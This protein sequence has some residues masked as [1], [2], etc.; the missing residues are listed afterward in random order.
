MKIKKYLI[1]VLSLV[2]LIIFTP[3]NVFAD[4]YPFWK[5]PYDNANHTH[6]TEYA[7]HYGSYTTGLTLNTTYT[8]NIYFDGI[9][10]T[11]GQFDYLEIPFLIY[12][13][14]WDNPVD[15]TMA[16]VPNADTMYYKFTNLFIAPTI[17]YTNG[18]YEN[19]GICTIE[20]YNYNGNSVNGIFKCNVNRVSDGITKI[21]IKHYLN[22]SLSSTASYG[23]FF[24]S[25]GWFNLIYGNNDN[26]SIANSINSQTNSITNAQ[27]GTTNAINDMNSN[28]TN[29]DGN[30][31]ADNAN[32]IQSF[33]NEIASNS[34]ITSL[35]VMPITFFQA[36]LNSVNGTCSPFNIGDLFGKNITF[37][38]VNMQA[39]LGNTL[40]GVIDTIISAFFIWGMSKRFIS[41]FSNMTSLKDGKDEVG[42]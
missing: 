13:D 38:C 33:Q 30:T 4:S 25:T 28:I 12:I 34:T 35:I 8:T 11:A 31:N 5:V 14:S 42:S 17:T 39:I 18:G 9:S 3:S 21:S 40:W 22:P 27:Q 29:S 23:L 6:Y 37:P 26:G 36:M 20:S 1:F 10:F 32:A 24:G 19:T 2:L 16:T 7:G 15:S 41:V